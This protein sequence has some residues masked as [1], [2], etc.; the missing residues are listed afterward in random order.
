MTKIGYWELQ[1]VAP[2][3][4]GNVVFRFSVS[5]IDHFKTSGNG[6]KFFEVQSAIQV[7]NDPTAIYLGLNRDGYEEGLCYIGKPRRFGDGT[8][9]P[10][11]PG[12]VFAVYATKDFKVFEWRWERA[13]ETNGDTTNDAI[14]RF[15]KLI[16]KR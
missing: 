4:S 6:E 15:G 3:G 11:P 8:S 16:W 13:D 2:S 10:G 5:Q 14:R 12:M 7:L 9:Y 1:G